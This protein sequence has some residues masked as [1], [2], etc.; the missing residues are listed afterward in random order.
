MISNARVVG[1][2]TSIL[3]ALADASAQPGSQQHSPPIDPLVGIWASE[4]AFPTLR[5]QLSVTRDPSGWKAQI[6][7]TESRFQASGDSI[8]FSLPGNLGQFRGALTSDRRAIR[9]FWIQPGGITVES[10]PHDPGGLDQPF[11]SPLTLRLH[12]PN[13]WRGNVEPLEDRFSLYLSIWRRSDSSLTGAFRNPELNQRGGWSRFRVTPSGDSVILTA[14]PDTAH[15]H[16]RHVAKFDSARKQ[17]VIWWPQIGR[18]LVL[19]PRAPEQAVGLFPRVPRGRKYTYTRPSPESD[20]WTTARA[21]TAGFDESQLERL[22]QRISDTLP[23]LG[24]APFIHSLLVARKGKLVLEEYF[25]GWDRERMHE[26]RSVGKTFA[27]V[28]LGAAMMQGIPVGPETPIAQ[29]LTRQAPFANPDPRKQKITLA[30]LMTHSSGLACDDNE[31]DSPGNEG[32]MQGQTRQLDWWKYTLDLPMSHDPGSYYAYCS[33]GSNLVGAGV[34]VATKTWLPEFFDRTIAR[35][36]QF[37]R[38][39]YNLTPTLEGYTAG[40]VFMRP[41]DLLKIGQ[42]FLDGGVWNGKRIVPQSW[43]TLST[44]KHIEWPYRS[45]NV[46]AGMDGYAW[47]LNTLKSGGRT[48]SEYEASGNGGQLLMVI[49]ELDLVVVF[50]AGNYQNFGVWGRFRDD[51]VP[52]AIIPAI[53][54]P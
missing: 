25:F 31:D 8:R 7:S 43:V 51:L 32:T 16:V 36:L 45:E 23:T 20:G 17:L 11:A 12:E 14:P 53:T 38:Y 27:S 18:T 28:M 39:Y 30:H 40:G 54:R 34:A 47:H 9:G 37:G 5:G 3:A 49:P 13:T 50:T 46:S 22:V 24:P 6:S 15:P 35:P 2:C 44:R 21:S 41:R 29:L 10:G 42:T 48:Y 26:T 4:T 19:T 1:A 52:N 33:G